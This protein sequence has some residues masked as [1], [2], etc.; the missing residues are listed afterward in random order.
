[1]VVNGSK[2]NLYFVY[3]RTSAGRGPS[4]LH[5]H[6]YSI[7]LVEKGSSGVTETGANGVTSYVCNPMGVDGTDVAN[8]K[9]ENTAV[10]EGKYYFHNSLENSEV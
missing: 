5:N 8:V 10:P 6:K 9:F 3:A 7:F 4:D 1:M 2:A